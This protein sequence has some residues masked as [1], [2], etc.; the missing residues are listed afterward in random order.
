M[1][2][3][4]CKGIGWQNS[5]P[6]FSYNFVVVSPN[7]ACAELNEARAAF[8]PYVGTAAHAGSWNL[9][10][11]VKKEWKQRWLGICYNKCYCELCCFRFRKNERLFSLAMFYVASNLRNLY[12]SGHMTGHWAAWWDTSNS[13]HVN[14]I[15]VHMYITITHIQNRYKM[16]SQNSDPPIL[17]TTSRM[18]KRTQFGQAPQ[19]EQH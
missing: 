6:W 10:L 8:L 5:R 7:Y 9:T 12:A 14:F 1:I 2:D 13:V 18:L 11:E 16:D 4:V 3:S 15:S 19:L 17:R